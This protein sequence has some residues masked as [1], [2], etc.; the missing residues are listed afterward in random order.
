M[1]SLSFYLHTITEVKPSSRTLM[2]KFV[3][4]DVI[5]AVFLLLWHDTFIRSDFLSWNQSYDAKVKICQ[6]G[7]HL[8]CKRIIR[9]YLRCAFGQLVLL[10]HSLSQLN[11]IFYYTALISATNGAARIFPTTLCR[12]MIIEMGRHVSLVKKTHISRVRIDRDLW[13]PLY[14]LSHNASAS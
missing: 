7:C 13:R 4:K 10:L 12:S 3:R 2:G 8:K 14:R 6:R 5:L 1:C 11:T 9:N